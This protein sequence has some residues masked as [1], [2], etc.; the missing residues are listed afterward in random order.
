VR[1]IVTGGSRGIG[2]SLTAELARRGHEV[3]ATARDVAG[4]A[5]IDDA[6]I[7]VAERHQLDVTDD[8]SVERLAKSVGAVDVLVN[9]AGAPLVSCPVEHHP[10]DDLREQFEV[11]V[12]GSVRMVQA[13]VPAMRIR[14]SGTV[15]NIGSVTGRVAQPLR[16]AANSSKFALE[17]ISEALHYELG[18]FGVRVLLVEPGATTNQPGKVKYDLA[19]RAPEYAQLFTAFAASEQGLT[20]SFPVQGPDQ[21]AV[22]VVDAIEGDA[23]E[24]RLLLGGDAHMVMS[25]RRATNDAEFEAKMRE[26][27][28]LDW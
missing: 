20:A 3:I 2:R 28:R 19:E 1:V 25:V 24:F 10:I 23:T 21:V 18:H 22:A 17:G 4:L 26:I 9:A 13:F 11:H 15:V 16:G 5:W 14:G 7:Q 8:S 12:V 6:A 27:L